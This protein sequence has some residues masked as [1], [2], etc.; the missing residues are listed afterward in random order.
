[1]KQKHSHTKKIKRHAQLKAH[2]RTQNTFNI[3]NRKFQIQT[4][5][6]KKKQQTIIIQLLAFRSFRFTQNVLD[7]GTP[8]KFTWYC[9]LLMEYQWISGS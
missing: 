4:T 9:F 6:Q 5:H 8:K 1:M 2:N 7:Q 3:D